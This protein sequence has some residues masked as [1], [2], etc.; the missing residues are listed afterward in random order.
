MLRLK[1]P[2]GGHMQLQNPYP[3]SRER[4]QVRYIAAVLE[5]LIDD[6]KLQAE[7]KY[8]LKRA[9]GDAITLLGGQHLALSK[10]ESLAG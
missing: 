4:Q 6:D 8:I 3:R 2:K 9:R 1:E 7:L 5:D 10:L